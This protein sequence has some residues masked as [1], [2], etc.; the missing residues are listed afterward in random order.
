MPGIQL[1][2]VL[3][4][5]YFINKASMRFYFFVSSDLEFMIKNVC[6]Y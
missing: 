6:S 3:L 4:D 5:E 2:F 1:H